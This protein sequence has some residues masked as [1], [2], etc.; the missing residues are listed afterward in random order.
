M[1]DNRV[2]SDIITKFFFNT[3]QLS[4]HQQ[5]NEEFLMALTFCASVASSSDEDADH[6]CYPLITGSIAE[7]YIVP[8]F[9]CVG[10]IDIMVYN[11]NQLAIPAGTAPPTQLPAEFHSHV[12]VYEIIDSKFNGYVYL[13]SSYLLTECIDDVIY[14]AVQCRRGCVSYHRAVAVELHGP[15]T[16]Q[17]FSSH[18]EP[19]HRGIIGGSTCST[20][21]NVP[22]TRCLSWP[23]QAADWTSRHREY[24]WPDSATVKRALSNGCD[25]VPVAHLLCRQDKWNSNC[26][27]RLS[28]SRAEIV[29][30]NSWI[31]VQQIVYHMLRIF[32]KTERLTDSANNAGVKAFSNYHIKTLMLWACEL[33]PRSWWSDDLNVVRIC[34]KLLHDLAVWLSDGRCANYFITNCNLLNFLDYS[35]FDFTDHIVG[36]LKLITEPW[37]SEWFINN[38]VRK[39]AQICLKDALFDDISTTAQLQ[40]AVSAVVEWR[41]LTS[42]MLLHTYA[43]SAVNGIAV[44]FFYKSLTMR[45]HSCYVRLLAQIDPCLHV[46]FI[47]VT[48]LHVAR[49]TTRHVLTNE[50]LDVLATAC[51]QSNDARRWLNAR[52]SSVLSLSQAAM[53]MKVVANNSRSTVQLIEIELSK[54]YLYR[55]LRCE[56][57]DSNSIYC[58]ANV[59]LAVLYYVAGQYPTAIDHCKLVTRS[60]DHSLCS[61]HVVQGELLPKMD[62][63]IDNVL[64]LSVFYQYVRAAALKRQDSKLAPYTSAFTTELFANYVYIKYLLAEKENCRMLR[65]TPSPASKIQRYRKRFYECT[66]MFIT[67]VLLFCVVS[68]TQCMAYDRGHCLSLIHI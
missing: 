65:H 52:H 34:V 44:V 33:K 41:L 13:V 51:L 7:F 39:C 18:P 15:A 32:V 62:D 66:D 57:S 25:V 56:D 8:M 30:L 4:L 47:A 43:G 5:A 9:S 46:Y 22:C 40:N 17:H 37:L 19:Y 11:N 42:H 63:D 24:G 29:L 58:L 23:T 38:Y 21:D 2:I 20:I 59:Y 28:F 61:S 10:D 36:K 68:C 1:A 3:C 31:P 16:V 14:S 6:S 60:Q 53:L 45:S 50:L 26:Q 48:F 12:I 67:D 55:A 35:H 64:G 49:K 54:A 27:W